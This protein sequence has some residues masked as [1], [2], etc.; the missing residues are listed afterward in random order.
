MSRRFLASLYVLCA[1]T[2][3][4]AA[5]VQYTS[6]QDIATGFTHLTGL[7]IADFNGDGKLDIAVT[8]DYAQ[9][10][11]VY[12]N[13]GNGS[14]SAPVVTTLSVAG[15]GGLGA[16]VAGDVNEDGKQDLIVSPV[17]GLQNDI[18]LL[19]NGDGTFTQGQ[20]LQSTSGFENAFL[21]DLNGDKHLDLLSGGNPNLN[22][23][24]GDGKGGF[25]AAAS[26]PQNTAIGFNTGLT[27]GDFNGDGIPDFASAA[28]GA[29]NFLF[30]QGVGDG[31]FLAPSTNTGDYLGNLSIDLASAD[32]NGDGKRDILLGEPDTAVVLF[33]NGNGTFETQYSQAEFIPLPSANIPAPVSPSAPLLATADMDGNGTADIVA[34][35]NNSDLVSVFLN[36]GSGTFSGTT[37]AFTAPLDPGSGSLQLADLNGDGL[38]DIVVINYETQNISIFLSIAPKLT[39]SVTVGSS[40]QQSLVGNAVTVSVQLTGTGSVV[41]TGKSRFR[42]TQP[43]SVSK[44]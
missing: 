9:N 42:A 37:P 44:P 3:S 41:P 43:P 23:E 38:P 33:G 18:V 12:L 8:D 20:T 39:P 36:D 40:A 15:I 22:V 35:D 2:L 14:F 5:T 27:V 10:I 21:V 32:F 25:Q 34:A 11:V 24:L 26:Q 17:A 13:N 30:Y 4:H 19:G 28:Y 1:A 31:S 29:E 6:R 16:L 7:A